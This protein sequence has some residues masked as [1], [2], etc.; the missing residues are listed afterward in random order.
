MAL[1]PVA[2]GLVAL[3]D[4]A[5]ALCVRRRWV[6]NAEESLDAPDH[7]ADWSGH[8]GANRTSNAIAF[9]RSVFEAAGKS[10][11]GLSRDR[12]GQCRNDDACIQY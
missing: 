8:Y 4:M 6:L 5:H 10:P 3:A 11:L 7:A 2:L 9:S 1:G 12:R